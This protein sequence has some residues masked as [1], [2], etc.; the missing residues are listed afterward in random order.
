MCVPTLRKH[1]LTE[2]VELLFGL[3]CFGVELRDLP[4]VPERLRP[5][6]SSQEER[7]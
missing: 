7:E 6:R 4:V 3:V 1:L 5:E 2:A